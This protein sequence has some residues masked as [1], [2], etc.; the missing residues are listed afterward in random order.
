MRILLLA[1]LLLLAGCPTSFTGS[2]TTPDGPNTCQAKCS[3]WGMELVGMV[4]MGENYTDGCICAV[5]GKG[6]AVA[7]ATAGAAGAAAG[8]VTQQRNAQQQHR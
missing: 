2:A 4:S 1:L 8:V 7:M 6:G 3:S 5:P